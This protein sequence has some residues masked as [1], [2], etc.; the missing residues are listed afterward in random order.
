MQAKRGEKQAQLVK[1][2]GKLECK[3][4]N[5]L[6]IRKSLTCFICSKYIVRDRIRSACIMID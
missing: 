1:S 4:S 5:F 3:Y 2:M 6:S